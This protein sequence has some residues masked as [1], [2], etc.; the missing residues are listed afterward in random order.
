M[1]RAKLYSIVDLKEKLH[2]MYYDPQS[3]KHQDTCEGHFVQ[4]AGMS[5]SYASEDFTVIREDHVLFKKHIRGLGKIPFGP[6][7]EFVQDNSK[8]CNEHIKFTF[9]AI[10]H[11]MRTLVEKKVPSMF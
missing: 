2:R 8:P 11:A 6:I 1:S 7:L 4:S 9:G 3:R 10:Y 5:T